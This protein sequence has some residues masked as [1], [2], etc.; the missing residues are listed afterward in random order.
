MYGFLLFN[1]R[2]ASLSPSSETALQIGNFETYICYATFIGPDG[3]KRIL[4]LP[5][6]V[7]TQ[8]NEG[9]IDRVIERVIE[10]CADYTAGNGYTNAEVFMVVHGTTRK[11]VW[12]A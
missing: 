5:I 8:V 12:R 3:K 4:S 6:E 9:N 2:G 11:I 10:G 1:M 7:L